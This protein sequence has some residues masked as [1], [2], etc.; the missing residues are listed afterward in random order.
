MFGLNAIF[1]L[2]EVNIP[3]QWTE[4]DVMKDIYQKYAN[5]VKRNIN[6]L[7]FIYDGNQ[8]NFNLKF[9]DVITDKKSNEMKVLVYSNETDELDI[10]S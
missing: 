2:D 6:T 7:V 1:T 3:I 8:L 4:N 10:P 9:K 5:K